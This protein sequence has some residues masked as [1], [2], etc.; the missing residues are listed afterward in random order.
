MSLRVRLAN[1]ND[2]DKWEHFAIKASAPH[3]AF[4][5]KWR[6]IIQ[7]AFGHKPH[8]AI[9]EEFNDIETTSKVKG[10]LPLFYVESI[11]FGRALISVPYLNGDG[12]LAD[13]GEAALE[14]VKWS[15]KLAAEIGA[16]YIELRHRER[17]QPLSE[18]KDTSL[19]THKVSMLL[20]LPGDPEV[21]FGSFPPKLRSQI[22]RPSK[23]GLYAKVTTERSE[24]RSALTHFYT[25]FSE[26][27]RDLGTPVFPLKLH[28]EAVQAFSSSCRIITVWQGNNP[29]AGGIT[30]GYGSTVE[31]P[32]AAALR[33]SSKFSPNMLLYW[34]ALKTASNDGYKI[35]D[36]G[37]STPDSGPHRFKAQWRSAAGVGSTPIQLHWYY[38]YAVHSL[39]DIT[40][41]NP[42]FGLLV[43]CWKHLPLAVT[44]NLGPYLTRGLP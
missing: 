21:L 41:S 9:V 25:V 39:P 5:W 36:F 33:R 40:P 4:S 27:M 8:Y 19:R 30:I 7:N 31:I 12:I 2:E 1:N 22:R 14:L 15:R 18:D 28:Q 37:R 11:L 16:G 24:L 42:K 17:Y 38:P 43:S 6:Q 44:N 35:F 34:E 26:H 3:H 20:Q 13:S 10:I 23:S 32:W 29:V